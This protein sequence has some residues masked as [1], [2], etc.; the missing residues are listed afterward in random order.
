MQ[1]FLLVPV[2]CCAVEG[3][4]F[5]FT[6][7]FVSFEICASRDGRKGIGSILAGALY[8]PPR[9]D[10]RKNVVYKFPVQPAFFAT[11]QKDRNGLMREKTSTKTV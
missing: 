7:K 5:R 4:S 10:R 3:T 8:I 9:N 6:S 11:L 1:S 2:K